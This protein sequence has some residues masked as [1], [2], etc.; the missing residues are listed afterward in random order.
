MTVQ[1]RQA[2]TPFRSQTG[3]G[4]L[5][6]DKDSKKQVH[7]DGAEPVAS[8]KRK[9][10]YPKIEDGSRKDI[11][12]IHDA[13]QDRLARGLH[14][15]TSGELRSPFATGGQSNGRE[16]L[17]VANRHPGPWFHKGRDARSC[18]FAR[19]QGI[20]ARKFAHGQQQLNATA[21]A[22]NVTQNPAIVAMD[23]FRCL[24]TKRAT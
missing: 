11:G 22:G 20:T 13:A 17:S 3:E 9:V 8:L 5:P 1:N 10:V 19:T 23:R 24:R 18:D 6:L 7:Q 15:Q 4:K 21:C 16:R 14:A 12:E 2:P